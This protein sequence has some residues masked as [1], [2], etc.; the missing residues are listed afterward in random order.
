MFVTVCVSNSIGIVLMLMVLIV[1]KSLYLRGSR[2]K[3]LVYM[4]AST[5]LACACDMAAFALDG[6]EGVL[7]TVLIYIV[8]SWLF[9]AVIV[10]SFCWARLLAECIGVKMSKIFRTVIAVVYSFGLLML[11]LNIFEPI[12]FSAPGNVYQ[13]ER[14]YWIYVA[15]GGFNML[16]GLILYYRTKAKGGLLV[17]FPTAIFV[18]PMVAGITV[19]SL[20]YGVS[21]IW[22]SISVSIV[23]MI[24][25]MKN[26]LIYIDQLTGI[27]NR[28][29]LEKIR[30]A[31]LRDSSLQY[32]GIMIDLNDFKGINDTYGHKFGDK[33]LVDTAAIIS[34]AVGSYGSVIRYA[35]D[36]FVVVLTV[37]DPHTIN[38]LLDRITSG[39]VEFNQQTSEPYKLSASLGYHIFTQKG[40]EIDEF[41]NIIDAKMYENKNRYHEIKKHI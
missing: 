23:G 19:Q 27:Y 2:L 21:V 6:K 33:A 10:V 7:Y 12:V 34:K 5:I 25:S 18:L 40:Q 13:R 9:L 26:E 30:A 35:G 20:F 32:T 28:Y 22:V 39:F 31:M 8:N 36:E 37:Y 24:S 3:N 15:I 17:E 14:F 1:N 16:Y 4:I 38:T 41:I 11:V 29:Y